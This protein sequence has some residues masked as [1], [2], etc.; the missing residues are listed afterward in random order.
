MVDPV[1]LATVGVDAIRYF[2]LREVPFGADSVFHQRGSY[3]PN[4]FRSCQRSRKSAF[5]EPP[6]W[7]VNISAESCP[8]H[9][10]Q[11]IF[12]DSLTELAGETKALVEA[13]MDAMQFST[14]D[15]PLEVCFANQQVYGRDRSLGACKG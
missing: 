14:T 15:R 3:Q 8:R 10:P 2:L 13:S 12:D 5:R 6:P 9:R 4:K 11:E 7:W 1:V